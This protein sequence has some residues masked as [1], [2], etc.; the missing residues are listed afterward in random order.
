MGH[1]TQLVPASLGSLV[2]HCFLT[3]GRERER[4][5]GEVE[6]GPGGTCHK[7]VEEGGEVVGREDEGGGTCHSDKPGLNDGHDGG[8]GKDEVGEAQ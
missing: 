2:F 1:H 5:G 8:I 6:G 3:R 4:K 7:G